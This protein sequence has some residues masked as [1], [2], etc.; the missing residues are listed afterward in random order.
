MEYYLVIKK[1]EITLFSGKRMELKNTMLIEARFKRSKVACFPSSAEPRPITVHI[2][3]YDFMHT[4][5][6]TNRGLWGD[7]RGKENVRERK[8]LKYC[9]YI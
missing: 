7:R 9:I 3:T 1:N 5:T 6:Y 2:N 4:H 8:I